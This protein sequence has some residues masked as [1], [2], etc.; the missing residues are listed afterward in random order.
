MQ[1]KKTLLGSEL[2]KMVIY[3]IPLYKM[4]VSG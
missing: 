3:S 1:A 2:M 4:A